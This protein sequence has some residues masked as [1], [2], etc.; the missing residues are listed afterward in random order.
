MKIL[1]AYK[2]VAT[3]MNKEGIYSRYTTYRPEIADGDQVC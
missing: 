1:R 2:I 3:G